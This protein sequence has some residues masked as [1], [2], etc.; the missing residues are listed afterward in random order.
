MAEENPQNIVIQTNTFIGSQYAHI[1][2]IVVNDNEITIEFIY[3]NPREE[4]K[5]AQVVSRVT[6]PRDAAYGL[7][8][9]IYNARQQ[10]EKQQKEKNA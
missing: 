9:A 4:V 1:V 6:M 5:E 8:Q 2:G 10:Y 7:A 3:K